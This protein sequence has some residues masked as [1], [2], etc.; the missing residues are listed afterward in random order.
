MHLAQLRFLERVTRRC[1][2]R[3]RI[4]HRRIE[5]RRIE[6]IAEVIVGGDIAPRLRRC[7]VA[8]PMR[9]RIEQAKQAFGASDLAERH[10]I[11]GKQLEHGNGV[12]TR[13]FAQRPRFVPADRAG[14]CEPHERQPA[15]QPDDRLGPL[16]VEPESMRVATRKDGLD[17][18]LDQAAVDLVEDLGK[19]RGNDARKNPSAGDETAVSANQMLAARAHAARVMNSSAACRAPCGST[20]WA[21]RRHDAFPGETRAASLAVARIADRDSDDAAAA[22]DVRLRQDRP[23]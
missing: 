18:T 22:A 10:G 14:G 8:Q 4:G 1:K 11:G 2:A 13:P 16:A 5:P 21:K 9:E 17:P 6:I 19:S 7:V 3:R 20:A 23:F 15:R 12:G